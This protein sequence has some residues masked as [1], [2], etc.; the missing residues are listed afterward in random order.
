MAIIVA[1]WYCRWLW[2]WPRTSLLP[3]ALVPVLSRRGNPLVPGTSHLPELCS[4]IEV[5]IHPSHTFVCLSLYLQ[6]TTKQALRGHEGCAIWMRL[7][8]EHSSVHTRDMS[9][10]LYADQ[11][12]S[13][14]DMTN[15]ICSPPV[16]T[17]LYL[18]NLSHGKS[19]VVGGSWYFSGGAASS[20]FSG[21]IHSTC[22]TLPW[23]FSVCE[24]AHMTR[25]VF[26]R[27]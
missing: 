22:L 6:S 16:T 11:I 4:L 21:F 27:F 24:G 1:I 7:D 26:F 17:Y 18:L 5:A 8:E 3:L 14:C 23:K 20:A 10:L 25:L 15:S 12:M 2:T 9:T 19:V 13:N